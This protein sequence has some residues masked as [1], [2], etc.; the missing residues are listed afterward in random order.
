MRRRTGRVTP[1]LSSATCWAGQ[2]GR[3]WERG[4]G[5]TCSAVRLRALRARRIR[6]KQAAALGRSAKPSTRGEGAARPTSMRGAAAV[7]AA[8]IAHMREALPLRRLRRA[9]R[10]RAAVPSAD[11]YSGVGHPGPTG[12]GR[13][14][15]SR[16]SSCRRSQKSSSRAVLSARPCTYCR[17]D[18]R[19]PCNP[20]P[21][22]CSSS[23]GRAARSGDLPRLPNHMIHHRLQMYGAERACARTGRAAMVS[24]AARARSECAFHSP[25][26]GLGCAPWRCPGARR[27]PA[28]YG[29]AD[30]TLGGGRRGE[31]ERGGGEGWREGQARKQ[32]G[33]TAGAAMSCGRSRSS[34]SRPRFR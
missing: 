28:E 2:H 6:G 24:G 31:E 26:V 10:R 7:G 15:G 1:S 16:P 21:P 8:C 12:S 5:L 17:R 25:R 22:P 18:C 4:R 27:A 14:S 30:R 19:R 9:P 33:G 32:D 13:A 34:Q 23:P 3:Y 29:L 11:W 20:R